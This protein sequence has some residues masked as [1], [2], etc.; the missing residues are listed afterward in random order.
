MVETVDTLSPPHRERLYPPTVALSMFMQQ[1]LDADGSCQSVVNGHAD[2]ILYGRPQR[3]KQ[4]PFDLTALC[5]KL[6]F[7]HKESLSPVESCP[8]GTP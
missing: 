7:S 2:I 3:P 4:V 8:S 6:G 5:W 1:T